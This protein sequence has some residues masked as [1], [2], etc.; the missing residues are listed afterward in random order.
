MVRT[1]KLVLTL[2]LIACAA[3]AYADP[4][5]RV[6]R[7]NYVTGA[8]SF[9]SADAPDQWIQATLNR[10]LTAGD[11]LWADNFSRAELHVGSTALRMGAQTS[12]DVLNL[13]D[14]TLQL[15]LAQGTLNI[16]VRELVQGE[17]V[18]IA[19]PSGAVLIKQPGSY[20]VSA[21]PQGDVSRVVVSFGQAD[22]ITPAQTFT[23]PSSQAA[24]FAAVASPSFELATYATAD[25]LDRWSADRDRREDRVTSTRYVSP[26]MT[27]YE[28]LDQYGAWRTL[29]EYG[30]VWVPAR[31]ATGWAP[32]RF[33]HWIWVSPWGW[34]L[35]DD[36]PWGFAPFHYGRWVWLDGHWA[37]APGRVVARPVYA[38]ALVA[39]VGG[40]RASFSLTISSGPAVGWFPLGWR[41]PYFPAFQASRTFVRNV[42]VTHVTNVTNVTHIYNNSTNVT[43][44]NYVNRNNPQAVTV[45]PQQAFVSATP[46]AQSAVQV[47]PAQLARAEVIHAQAPA[48]PVRAS[49]RPARPGQRPPPAAVA[50]EVVA[51]TPPA[52]PAT[53]ATLAPQDSA[54]AQP[55]RVEQEPRVHVIGRERAEM[56]ATDKGSPPAA[57]SQ[58][59]APAKEGTPASTSGVAAK[60]APG[61]VARPP[62]AA[63]PKADEQGTAAAPSAISR[64][65]QA[66]ASKADET[67]TTVAPSGVALPPQAAAPKAE[68]KARVQTGPQE[69]AAQ[70]APERRG[71]PAPASNV[72]ATEARAGALRP[73]QADPGQPPSPPAARAAERAPP[74][75]RPAEA[76][77]RRQAPVAEA[78]PDARPPLER[79][80]SP[81]RS[82][83]SAQREIPGQQ[84]V[85]VEERRPPRIDEAA[86]RREPPR[87]QRVEPPAPPRAEQAVAPR[88][89]QPVPAPR[90]EPPRPS[91][92]E[93]QR[94]LAPQPASP[95]VQVAQPQPR[96]ERPPAERP[97]QRGPDLEP[98]GAARGP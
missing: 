58:A 27:G 39:F 12:L 46:V 65:P 5:G 24:S 91:Q 56:K 14:H 29:P 2:A 31:V 98:R 97:P 37:W 73:P 77:E 67:G 66:A 3:A 53:Q 60:E 79:E 44:I 86:V 68:E 30:A 11:R 16:R 51:V 78:R 10:P 36:A 84:P 64:P 48:Q 54:Q 21:D 72:T 4:P 38:P 6:G 94:V 43:N 13:D 71:P 62:Q 92:V 87:A 59:I 47:A 96:G 52:K 83:P 45:V 57:Q 63:A 55:R 81:A 22:V 93:M 17:R 80:R 19:T 33:G 61:T 41:D 69:R 49:F 74:S 76:R 8:V 20:R 9:A 28:D 18:E 89:V 50:R 82:E 7:V 42:N 85:A 23:V 15:R 25:E 26:Q 70:G 1:L 95:G 40:P 35:V 90:A 75:E 34:T 88:P 32:Y